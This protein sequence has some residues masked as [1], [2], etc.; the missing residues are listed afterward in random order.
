[1][2]ADRDPY[3]VNVEFLYTDHPIKGCL[4]W[5]VFGRKICAMGEDIHVFKALSDARFRK[6]RFD[7]RFLDKGFGVYGNK[8]LLPCAAGRE[9]FLYLRARLWKTLGHYW[10]LAIADCG[11]LGLQRAILRTKSSRSSGRPNSQHDLTGCQT[12]ERFRFIY[13]I[14]YA[15]RYA[16]TVP[17]AKSLIYRKANFLRI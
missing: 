5:L 9:R 4:R 15:I 6:K 7:V 1:M 12:V 3:W 14:R 13:A 17:M 2:P 16:I 10:W 11:S 8:V